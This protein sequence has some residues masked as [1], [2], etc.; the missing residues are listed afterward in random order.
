MFRNLL[1]VSVLCI[2]FC[3]S[4]SE[5]P[6][7]E[8]QPL[9]D[10]VECLNDYGLMLWYHEYEYLSKAQVELFGA[11]F[12]L[13]NAHSCYLYDEEAPVGKRFTKTYE[14]LHAGIW[15]FPTW[16]FP[17]GYN[18]VG[19]VSLE[20]LGLFTGCRLPQPGSSIED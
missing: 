14:C 7:R 4:C 20:E 12:D 10:F 19:L 1:V 2:A 5:G 3:G 6:G 15:T 11:S 8:P 9:D 16:N 13:L 18:V 17:D